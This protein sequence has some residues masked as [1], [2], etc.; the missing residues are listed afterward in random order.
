MQRSI[1]NKKPVENILYVVLYAIYVSLSSIYLFLPPLFGVLFVLFAKALKDKDTISLLF[2]S[3][4]LVLFE[5][6]KSYMIFSSIIYFTF[7]HKFVMPKI[8][9]NF[10]CIS[11]IK[12]SYI[13]LAYIGFYLFSILLS[14]IFL[15]P[16]PS[17]NYYIVFYI[18]IEFFLVSLL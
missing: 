5:A 3:F 10:S 8:T 2:I 14:N 18:V 7:I 6:D 9:Q 15:I 4:C 1:T 13:L 17:I 16:M 11:C 12:V